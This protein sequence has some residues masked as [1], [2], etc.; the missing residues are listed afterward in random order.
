MTVKAV[1]AKFAP[2]FQI[3]R[4][5]WCPLPAPP[6]LGLGAGISRDSQ[7]HQQFP[8][9]WQRLSRSKQHSS[10]RSILVPRY[11]A[12]VPAP[13]AEMAAPFLIKNADRGT[14][15]APGCLGLGAGALYAARV[16]FVIVRYT[17]HGREFVCSTSTAKICP[18]R[19]H[20]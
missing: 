8:P 6:W 12:Q 5:Q 13:S 17:A 16:S 18:T 19:P 15:P 14:V 7:R 20:H 1:P 2:P 3:K 9:N 11:H 4:A 10:G